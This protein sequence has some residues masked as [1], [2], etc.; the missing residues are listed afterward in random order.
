[1]HPTQCLGT[2]RCAYSSGLWSPTLT[3]VHHSALRLR[4][5]SRAKTHASR[6]LRQPALT[7]AVG[8]ARTQRRT[9]T[10]APK[11]AKVASRKGAGVGTSGAVGAERRSGDGCACSH[12][13]NSRRRR[14]HRARQRVT[15]GCYEQGAPCVTASLPDDERSPLLHTAPAQTVHADNTPLEHA[16]V[17]GLLARC[18]AARS[19]DRRTRCPPSRPGS[20][21]LRCRTT[22]PATT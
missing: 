22:H 19:T 18:C 5:N 20:I 7:D 4:R 8:V 9:R 10:P 2:S 12:V 6:S 3:P 1:M 21:T 16:L 15:P 11:G 17:H 14:G 13:C